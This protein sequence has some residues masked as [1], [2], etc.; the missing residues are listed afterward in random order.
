M[1]LLVFRRH[2]RH[3]SI[4]FCF[5]LLH[6]L[7]FLFNHCEFSSQ[8]TRYMWCHPVTKSEFQNSR[9]SRFEM[10][11][12]LQF[13]LDHSIFFFFFIL[14]F[15]FFFLGGGVGPKITGYIVPPCNRARIS[16]FRLKFQEFHISLKY[17]SSFSSCWITLKF[18]TR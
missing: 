9:N 16:K 1:V 7:E 15:F 2:H 10:L 18:F 11:L 6:F 13:L 12:L 3:P 8:E 5:K 17:Y 14:L 4:N